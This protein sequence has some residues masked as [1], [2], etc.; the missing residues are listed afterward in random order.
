VTDGSIDRSGCLVDWLIG[1]LVGCDWLVGLL[2]GSQ[3]GSF[4]ANVRAAALRSG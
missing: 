1:W 4:L 3:V 2:V